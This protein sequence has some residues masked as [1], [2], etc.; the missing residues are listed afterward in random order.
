MLLKTLFQ[1]FH[2]IFGKN[3]KIKHYLRYQILKIQLCSDSLSKL[4]IS[5]FWTKLGIFLTPKTWLKID[6]E[7]VLNDN[8][9]CQTWF[10]C[11]LFIIIVHGCRVRQYIVHFL[12]LS[13]SFNCSNSFLI[14]KLG[15]QSYILSWKKFLITSLR[16]GKSN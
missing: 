12:N 16:R 3:I 2:N 9:F 14:M 6:F 11:I 4:T 13:R 8:G 15:N 7:F 1:Y 10:K 5:R